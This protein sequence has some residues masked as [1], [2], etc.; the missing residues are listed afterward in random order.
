MDIN[1]DNWEKISTVYEKAL[2]L[3]SEDREA[4]LLSTLSTKELE[5]VLKLLSADEAAN[6]FLRHTT[7]KIH[8]QHIETLPLI[9]HTVG[10]FIIEELIGTGGMADV[11]IGSRNDERFTQKVAIKVLKQHYNQTVLQQFK[12]ERSLLS[13][14]NH[15]GIAKIF[16]GGIL[17]NDQPY[18][19]MEYI[20]GKHLF[21]YIDEN[22]LNL[23]DRLNLFLEICATVNY[24]HQNLI[25]HRDIKPSNILINQDGQSKLL[26]F[27]IAKSLDTTLDDQ[28][29]TRTGFNPLTISYASP[30]QIESNQLTMQTDIFSLG[31][32]LYQLLSGNS[33]YQENTT[34]FER[35]NKIKL[36]KIPLA[37]NSSSENDKAST[38]PYSINTLQGDL[39]C[40]IKKAMQYDP[41]QRYATV[42]EF[43]QDIKNY[44]N[45]KPI[46]AKQESFFVLAGKLVKRNPIT[47][48]LSLSLF[49]LTAGFTLNTYLDN[50]E[51]IKQRDALIQEKERST[52]LSTVLFDTLKLSNTNN[53]TLST[54]SLLANASNNILTLE[55]FSTLERARLLNEIAESQENLSDFNGYL[56][57]TKNL[58]ELNPNFSNEELALIHIKRAEILNRGRRYTRAL[59]ELDAA[60]SLLSNSNNH[61]LLARAY[62]EKAHLEMRNNSLSEA[63]SAIKKSLHHYSQYQ[64]SRESIASAKSRLSQILLDQGKYKKANE[65]LEEICYELFA[66]KGYKVK[67]AAKCTN[68]N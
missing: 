55:K 61:K 28:N 7:Q 56:L 9:G 11:Y 40:I 12:R 49:V 58:L 54:T 65:L 18:F 37:S 64:A 2:S 20:E 53:E 26:D 60:F 50:I 66:G 45:N 46:I 51:I 59:G 36:E 35:V 52:Q 16:D 39:D 27:G 47:S 22:E 32:L 38:P 3:S 33:P 1:K 44:L 63:E 8:A 29:V 5:Q 68:F 48:F 31:R 41:T 34:A 21:E 23:K 6:N 57:T 4:Y 43:S 19:V 13:S 62:N 24:A 14:L 25:I 67:D 42:Q 15:N 17:S 10:N 30:E